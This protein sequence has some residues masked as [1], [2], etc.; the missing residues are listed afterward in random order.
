MEKIPVDLAGQAYDYWLGAECTDEIVDRLRS[1]D[2]D[3]YFVIADERI[4]QLHAEPFHRELSRRAPAELLFHP[5]GERAKRL[6]EVERVIDELVRRGATRAS[7]IVAFGGGVTGN[8]AGLVA[9]LLF[10]GIRLVHVPTTLVSIHDSVISLKQAVNAK[11]GK[12][13][14]G[15]YYVPEFVLADTAYLSTLP[16]EHIRS[17]MCEVIK[18]ALAI[19]PHQIPWLERTLRP[20]GALD[21][22]IWAEIVR[23]C[24][25]AK[26]LVM[27]GDPYE[28]TSGLVLE[29]GHT[30][31]HAIEHTSG[32]AISHGE[33]VGLGMLVAARVSQLMGQLPDEAALCHGELLARAGA[34]MQRPDGADNLEIMEKVLSDNKRGHLS[35]GSDQVPMVLLADLGR[36]LRTAHLPLVPVAVDLVEE[37]LTV[38]DRAPASETDA[39]SSSTFEGA[40]LA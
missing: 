6:G 11:A 40:E 30:V 33:A 21:P 13:M 1:L 29:Y 3:R 35:H 38:V 32:G 17:G 12:N 8:L 18:N 10:R 2:A 31:G 15:T 14:I 25:S 36:P 23:E 19:C 20:D 7:C 37:A 22:K 34:P 9:A 27:N 28:K 39:S 24:I 26:L 4:R 16:A 5:H